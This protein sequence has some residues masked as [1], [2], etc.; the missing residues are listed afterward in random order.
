MPEAMT[1]PGLAHAIFLERAA[2]EEDSARA[3]FGQAAFLVLRLVDLVATP[4]D[5]G[6]A[7]D[8]FGYQAAATTRYCADQLP[9]GPARDQLL[10]LVV[11][12]TRAQQRRAPDL[13]AATM[14]A[15]T[16]FLV[17]RSEHD[18][19]LDVLATLE[20][21]VGDRLSA[22]D[23]IDA[24]LVRA[25]IEREL[26]RFD[27][28]MT[29]Y[30]RAA[31]L[32]ETIHD[33]RSLLLSRLGR[34]NVF[35]G[36]GNL[37]EAERWN[38]EVVR[39]AEVAGEQ[40]ALARALHGLGVVLGAR[41]QVPDAIPCL[42]LACE[43]YPDR[44]RSLRA[45]GDLGLALCRLGEVT[46]AE[47]AFRYVLAH[48]AAPSVV[49]NSTLE[50]MH[51][52]SFRR[53]RLAFERLRAECETASTAMTPNTQIDFRL[54]VGIGLARFEQWDRAREE[55]EGALDL[56]RDHGLHEF[57]FRIER[58]LNGIEDVACV[59]ASDEAPAPEPA[60][61]TAVDEVSAALAGLQPVR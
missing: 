47:C 39:D 10:T 23:A 60:W 2:Q 9:A 26:A 52:A 36:R 45:M 6:Q 48:T 42:W 11:S 59:E 20:H 35:W 24:A 19:A 41:G 33:T 21:L 12:A 30:E 55:L 27:S 34:A 15:F 51:C 44:D 1:K 3:R 50:L 54:K 57:E 40:D 56:A 58:I 13:M 43:K 7:A 53:D 38:R 31:A 16:A 46:S 8:L 28:A 22:R 4:S 5:S 18:G 17:E 49:H 61:A 32:A 25:R 14:L 29:A 37:A